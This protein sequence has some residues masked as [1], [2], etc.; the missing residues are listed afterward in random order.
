MQNKTYYV[1]ILASRRNGR[2]YVG[3]TNDLT[4][5]IQEH[6]QGISDGFTKKYKIHNLVYYESTGHVESALDREKQLKNWTRKWKLDLIEKNN[7]DWQDLSLLDSGS[8]PE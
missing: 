4:R 2:L 8:S 1:Y 3:V 6:K 7:P 5:R